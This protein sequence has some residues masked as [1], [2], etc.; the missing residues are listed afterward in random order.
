MTE[1]LPYS[2]LIMVEVTEEEIYSNIEKR[3]TSVF[4]ESF[5]E[6]KN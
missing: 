6:K 2:S 4:L 5:L 3:N 1:H